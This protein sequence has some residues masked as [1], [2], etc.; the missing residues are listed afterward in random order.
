MNLSYGKS[1]DTRRGATQKSVAEEGSCEGLRKKLQAAR[2]QDFLSGRQEGARVISR[3]WSRAEGKAV[4]G[5]E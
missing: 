5:W 1:L 3:R 2:A 4:R